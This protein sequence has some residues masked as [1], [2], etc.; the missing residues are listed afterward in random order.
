MWCN[1][2]NEQTLSFDIKQSCTNVNGDKL[3]LGKKTRDSAKFTNLNKLLHQK[4]ALNANLLI[5]L[6]SG[7]KFHVE[8]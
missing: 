2:H 1:Y 6:M 5:K 3:F 8:G 7:E 4:I